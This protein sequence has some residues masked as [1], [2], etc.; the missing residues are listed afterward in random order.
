MFVNFRPCLLTVNARGLLTASDVTEPRR[1]TSRPKPSSAETGWSV[2]IGSL[3][4]T[5]DPLLPSRGLPSVRPDAVCGVAARIQLR[6]WR[7]QVSVGQA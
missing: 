6:R 5:Q 7:V 2:A 1:L 3:R 4:H